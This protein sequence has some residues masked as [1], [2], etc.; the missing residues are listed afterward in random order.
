VFPLQD[1]CE[2]KEAQDRSG[3][4]DSKLFLETCEKVKKIFDQMLEVRKTGSK[5]NVAKVRINNLWPD[6]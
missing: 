1:F 4:Q 3:T 2:E 5:K 6:L